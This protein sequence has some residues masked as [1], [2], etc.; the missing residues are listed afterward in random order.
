VSTDE[1]AIIADSD[2]VLDLEPVARPGRTDLDKEGHDLVASVA[3]P[4][5]RE[6]ANGVVIAVRLPEF[7][8]QSRVVVLD[9]APPRFSFERA[10]GALEVAPHDLH[11]LLRHRLLPKPGGFEGVLGIA[12]DPN[13]DQLAF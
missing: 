5:L 3:W 8:G 11:V 6:L 13:P 9:V 2:C 12:A 10:T 1:D 4:R 7:S